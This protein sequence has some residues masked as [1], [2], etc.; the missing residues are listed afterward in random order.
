MMQPYSKQCYQ[1]NPLIFKWDQTTAGRFV[2]KSKGAF[3]PDVNE[4]NKSGYSRVVGRLNILSLLAS[5]VREIHYI[6]VLHCCLGFSASAR[7]HVTA[8]A[9]S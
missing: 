7:N 6:T 9:S 1:M 8:R 3:T 2:D 5:F 4:A